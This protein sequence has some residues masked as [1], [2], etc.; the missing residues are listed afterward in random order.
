[1]VAH[2]GR[3]C[4]RGARVLSSTVCGWCSRCAQHRTSWLASEECTWHCCSHWVRSVCRVRV[5]Q[6]GRTAVLNCGLTAWMCTRLLSPD[7]PTARRCWRR[8]H[9]RSS[10]RQ[11]LCLRPCLCDFEGRSSIVACI[12]MLAGAAWEARRPRCRGVGGCFP[13]VHRTTSNTTVKN[14]HRHKTTAHSTQHTAHS[15]QH[16][17]HSTQYTATHA[18]TLLLH[19]AVQCIRGSSIEASMEEGSSSRV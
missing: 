6:C 4:A 5:D 10:S 7:R 15:T 14:R 13:R 8:H 9:T 2:P 16:T 18:C 12:V 1:M 11:H 17:A 19:R 3:T